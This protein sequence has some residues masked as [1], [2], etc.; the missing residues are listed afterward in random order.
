[1]IGGALMFNVQSIQ[2]SFM[3]L[4]VQE[5]NGEYFPLGNDYRSF[6]EQEYKSYF[7]PMAGVFI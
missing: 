3:P 6:E 2:K 4:E 7:Q 5:I 1:M